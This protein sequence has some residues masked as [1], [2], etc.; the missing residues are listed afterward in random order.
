[1]RTHRQGCDAPCTTRCSLATRPVTAAGSGCSASRPSATGPT[2][3]APSVAPSSSPTNGSRRSGNS[4]ATRPRSS[5]CSMKRSQHEHST[6]GSRSSTAKTCG[7]TRSRASP[8]CSTTRSSQ[9]PARLRPVTGSDKPTVA[10]PVDFPTTE[11][12][13]TTVAP[14]AGQHTEE[15]LL[16]L[17]YD[18]AG[19]GDLKDDNVIP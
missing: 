12:A 8:D 19:I 1:M 6:S 2:S 11:P 17:G 5:P 15:I 18:W 3:C 10:A 14:A 9:H 4:C 16:E 13:E 7:G